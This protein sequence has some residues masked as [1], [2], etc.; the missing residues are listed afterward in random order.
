MFTFSYLKVI[1]FLAV[2]HTS[3]AITG[4]A[5]PANDYGLSTK[6]YGLPPHSS[7]LL[8]IHLS[9]MSTPRSRS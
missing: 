4:Q 8:S 3:A 5:R 1:I 9:A 7:S 2:R 6:D